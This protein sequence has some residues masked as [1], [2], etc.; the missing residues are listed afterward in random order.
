MSFLPHAPLAVAT[1]L[2]LAELL[3]YAIGDRDRFR[4][5]MFIVFLGLAGWWLLAGGVHV[6]QVLAHQ[7][8]R[9]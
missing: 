6:L 8:A 1:V 4:R 2:A 9:K 7:F 5:L 3:A